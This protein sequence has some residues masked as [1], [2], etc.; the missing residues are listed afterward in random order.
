MPFRKPCKGL[1]GGSARILKDPGDFG[2]PLGPKIDESSII[3]DS[4]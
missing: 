1:L 3:S 2:R 4:L